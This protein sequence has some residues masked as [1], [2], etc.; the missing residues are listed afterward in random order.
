[1]K[2]KDVMTARSLKYCSP[3]TNLQNAAE[4]MKT[5]NCGALPVV[6]K[7]NKVLGIVTDRDICLALAQE[8][9]AQLAKTTV[10][11]VM[12]KKVHTV[13]V[14]DDI[15]AAYKQM[16]TNKVGRLPVVDSD[17]KLKGIV[18]LHKLISKT[19]EDGAIALGQPSEPGENLGKTIHAVTQRYTGSHAIKS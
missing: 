17:G 7:E 13:H 10:G 18:S 5:A 14:D 11:K 2:I 8:Q 1:M 9:G 16:R 15:S 4:L 19:M 3:E 12:P 6:D